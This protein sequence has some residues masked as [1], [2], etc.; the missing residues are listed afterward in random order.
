MFS[1]SSPTLI[2]VYFITVKLGTKEIRRNNA[3]E[4]AFDFQGKLFF[5]VVLNQ[6]VHFSSIYD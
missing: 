6:V 3:K 2:L 4:E 1:Q 5:S